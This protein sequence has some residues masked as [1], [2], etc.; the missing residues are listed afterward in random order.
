[1]A[2]D[3]VDSTKLEELIDLIQDWH[4]Y[5]VECENDTFREELY[6]WASLDVHGVLEECNVIR[7]PILL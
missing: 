1:M 6:L 2:Q 4:Q 5:L 7:S 3:D